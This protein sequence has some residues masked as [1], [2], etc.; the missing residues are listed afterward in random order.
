VNKYE[1]KEWDGAEFSKR[2][3]FARGFTVNGRGDLS[4]YDKN[5][6]ETEAIPEGYW[7]RVKLLKKL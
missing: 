2:I 5:S 1:V 3:V 4:F 7:H 6:D